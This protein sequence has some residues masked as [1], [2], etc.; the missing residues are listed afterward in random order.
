MLCFQVLDELGIQIGEQLDKLPTADGALTSKAAA[1]AN[2]P[3]QVAAQ[4]DVDADLQ[5]RLE[6]LRR[7]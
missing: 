2:K 5:A 7:E 1:T 4:S 3:A 6:N